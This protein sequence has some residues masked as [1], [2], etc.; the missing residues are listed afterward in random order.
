MGVRLA[1]AL[2]VLSVSGCSHRS[3]DGALLVHAASPVALAALADGSLRYGERLSGRILEVDPDGRARPAPV[4]RVAVSTDGQRGLLGVAVDSRERT[5][6]AWTDPAGIMVVG[7]VAPGPVRWLWRGPPSARLANGGHL[8]LA[9]DGRL[10][11][12]IGDRQR[13]DR[14]GQ[15]LALDPDGPPDQEPAV[16][17]AGWNNPFAFGFSPSGALW[18][19]DNAPGREPERIARVGPEGRLTHEAELAGDQIAPAGLVALSDAELVLCAYLTK[20]LI[21]YDVGTGRRRVLAGNCQTG[22]VQLTGH[23]LAYANDTEI[24]VLK[25]EETSRRQGR[26]PPRQE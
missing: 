8:A 6:A 4:A 25:Y 2:L 13:G 14:S 7:Q 20:A 16:L 21:R 12:G 17:S 1:A 22:V 18:V 26:T 19:A 24:R 10:V 5:F 11:V 3:A 23:K 15:L 9:P